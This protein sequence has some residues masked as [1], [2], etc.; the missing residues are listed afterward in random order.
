MIRALLLASAL[1]AAP[2]VAG[3]A[4]A[5]TPAAA[6]LTLDEVLRSS[7]RAAPQ[8]VEALAKVRSAEGRALTADGAFDTVFDVDGR[9]RALGYY[10]GTVASARATRPLTGNGGYV[11]GGY[12]VSRGG[13]P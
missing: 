8:I 4:G 5:Q 11:Y 7:A 3:P 12:R 13:F 1:L 6:P 2:A 10:D 9:S